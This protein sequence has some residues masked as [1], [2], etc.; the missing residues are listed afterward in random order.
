MKSRRATPQLSFPFDQ[1]P[2]HG[3]TRRPP[4]PSAPGGRG[5][6]TRS[7]SAREPAPRSARR[8]YDPGVPIPGGADAPL[9]Y[10]VRLQAEAP[11]D[12]AELL[13]RRLVEM[14]RTPL[15]LLVH[16]NRSTMVSFRREDDAL[17][18]RVH[19]MFLNA[20]PEVVQALAQ[21]ARQRCPEAGRRLDLYVK[22]NRACIR[23]LDVEEIR[24]R[25]L[26]TRGEV[27]DLAAIYD[28]LNARYFGGSVDARIGW[29]RGSSGRR[30][31]IRMGAYYHD[32]RTILL[33]P[34]LDQAAVPRY[35]VELVVYHEML[36]QAVPQRRTASGRRCIHSPEFRARERMFH[37][38]ERARRWE[39]NNL[40]LLLRPPGRSRRG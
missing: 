21:Y 2:F 28:E 25:P 27:H 8:T 22:E 11:S 16:D 33:H 35:F 6:Q 36:H 26:T 7:P 14:V 19:R 3:R 37:D 30:R 39:K 40:G 1:G 4:A 9:P 12:E 38:Y 10:R 34:A 15:H 13:A 23:A 5:G 31:S 24:S 20:G 29:G 32:T 18:L 17:H